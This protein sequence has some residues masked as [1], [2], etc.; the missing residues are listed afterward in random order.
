MIYRKI[1]MPVCISISFFI[2]ACFITPSVMAERIM[3]VQVKQSQ[4]RATPS[5]LGKILAR[6][7]YGEKVSIISERAGWYKVKKMTVPAVVGWMN[8][9]S[10]ANPRVVLKA[11]DKTVQGKTTTEEVALAGKGFNASIEKDY[12]KSKSN[13]DYTWVDKMEKISP[14]PEEV[15]AFLVEGNLSLGEGEYHE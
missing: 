8:A 7:S 9:S 14:T 11:G 13:L 3:A 15:T 2:A 1:I 6:M 10:L 5:Y 12:E 4:I